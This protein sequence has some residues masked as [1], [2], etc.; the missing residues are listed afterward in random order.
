MADR[1]S[2]KDL[3]AIGA[4]EDTPDSRVRLSKRS[5]ACRCSIVC[6]PSERLVSC[7]VE[8]TTERRIKLTCMV[9]MILQLSYLA[10]AESISDVW[11]KANAPAPW[12][13]GSVVLSLSTTETG[14]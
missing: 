5:L 1:F 14:T 12:E 8:R 7:V 9:V 6:K 10:H 11:L 2:C 13:T 4:A 3:S